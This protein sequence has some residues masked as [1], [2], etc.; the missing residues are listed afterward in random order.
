MYSVSVPAQEEIRCG[1]KYLLIERQ[2][3]TDYHKRKENPPIDS[4]IIIFIQSRIRRYLTWL[5][6][7]RMKRNEN[8]Y[9]R[10]YIKIG[11]LVTRITVQKVVFKSTK[12][13]RHHKLDSK[14]QELESRSAVKEVKMIEGFTIVAENRNNPQERD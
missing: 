8:I 13:E 10:F 4:K 9:C 11:V 3:K 2:F 14:D 7:T 12:I 6:V 5:R 1:T